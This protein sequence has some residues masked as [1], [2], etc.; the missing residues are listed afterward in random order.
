MKHIFRFLIPAAWAAPARCASAPLRA[1]FS[2]YC[3]WQRIEAKHLVS[4]LLCILSYYCNLAV[5][6]RL[7]RQAVSEMMMIPTD[8]G[9]SVSVRNKHFSQSMKYNK[10]CDKCT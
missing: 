4:H 5:A 9:I 7:E 6:S 2:V 1:L 10:F 3:F 8:P